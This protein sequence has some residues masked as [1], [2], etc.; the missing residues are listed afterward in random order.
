M[1]SQI[2]VRKIALTFL[3]EKGKIPFTNSFNNSH[4]NLF[5]RIIMLIEGSCRVSA[6]LNDILMRRM[7]EEDKEMIP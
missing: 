2:G 1:T 3:C 7:K 5:L 6:A 4:L